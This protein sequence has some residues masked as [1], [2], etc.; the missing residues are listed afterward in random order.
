MNIV[1][2]ILYQ[3]RIS[4]EQAAICAPGTKYDL[5]TYAQLGFMVQN[6][7][8][9]VLSLGFGQGQIVG[10]LVQDKIFHIALLL[11]LTRIGVVTV[12][13]RGSSLPAELNAAAIV[14]DAPGQAVSGVGRVIG[15][16]PEWIRGQGTPVADHNL[17]QSKPD[18]LCRL[19][20]TSGS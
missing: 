12:S 6:L 9:A 7:T 18:D 11:A 19:I 17:N 10:I 13:C 2:P 5:I 4:G 3:T 8:R 14:T 20:L 15:V 1:D 16:Q